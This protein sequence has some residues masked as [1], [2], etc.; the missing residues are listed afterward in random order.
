MNPSLRQLSYLIALEDSGSFSRAAEQCHVTQS[1]LSAGIR[2]LETTLRQNLVDRRRKKIAL[3]PFGHDIAA[4]SRKIIAQ[5]D[6]IVAKSRHALKPMSGPLR[7]GVIPTIAPYLLPR[8]LPALQ[9][10][11]PDLE[12]QLFE[13]L[14]ARLIE[15]LRGSQLDIVLMAFPYDTQGLQTLSLF[16]EDFILAC[17]RNT[18]IPFKNKTIDTDSLRHLNLLLLEDGHCLRDHA[19]SACNYIP[20]QQRKTFSATSMP[21]LIQ[22]VQHG[23][24]ATLLPMM[25][26][27][28][29]NGYSNIRLIPFRKPA[30]TREIGLVWDGLN[31]RAGDLKTFAKTI[32]DLQKS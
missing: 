32:R 9:K 23:Y 7:L 17:P 21:T 3:T 10:K 24:G 27:D 4:R 6:E 28:G 12:I 2:E 29:T 25:V 5:V 8:I 14:S 16:H 15:K 22:M 13:D 19:L 26:A 20:P 31:P 1:T 11:F 18:N 30:P